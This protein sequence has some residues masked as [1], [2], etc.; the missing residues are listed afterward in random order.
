MY[1]L[2]DILELAEAGKARANESEEMTRASM[3]CGREAVRL[4]RGLVRGS[5]DNLGRAALPRWMRSRL[6]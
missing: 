4:S 6:N 1:T 2:Q 3:Q 5:R